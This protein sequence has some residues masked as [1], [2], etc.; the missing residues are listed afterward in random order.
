VIDQLLDLV[1]QVGDGALPAASQIRAS[2]G[3]VRACVV[4]GMRTEGNPGTPKEYLID[5]MA[6]GFDISSRG[7]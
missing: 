2:K 6:R 3:D 5:P 4:R 7:K 1:R